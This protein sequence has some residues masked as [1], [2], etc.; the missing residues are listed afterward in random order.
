MDLYS[1]QNIVQESFTVFNV[2]RIF[3]VLTITF[4]ATLILTPLW[5]KLMRHYQMG[6]QIRPN[7][8]APIFNSLHKH[9]EGTPTTGGVLIW[10]TVTIVTLVFWWFGDA[11]DSFWSK[12]DF[13]S[14]SETWLP[15][16]VL[17]ATGILGLIDDLFGALR[18]GPRGG[19]LMMRVR[20]AL[21]AVI[22]VIGAWWF[23]FKLDFDTV[24]IPFL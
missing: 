4:F 12:I 24:N 20:V 19:G 8:N 3:T 17:I 9:K 16:G 1:T 18:I 13:F 7:E 2:L 10:L 21:Y 5:L 14:R 23:Y 6:K 15:L 22:G 11:F